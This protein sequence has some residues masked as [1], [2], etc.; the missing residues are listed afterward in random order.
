MGEMY[1]L[2]FAIAGWGGDIAIAQTIQVETWL[3]SA[4]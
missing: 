1:L 3:S 2:S 4:R